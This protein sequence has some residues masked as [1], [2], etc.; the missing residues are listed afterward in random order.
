MRI[1]LMGYDDACMLKAEFSRQRHSTTKEVKPKS[2]SAE[3]RFLRAIDSDNLTNFT[4]TD[5]HRYI[6]IKCKEKGVRY[7]GGN[8]K[9][10]AVLKSALANFHPS[11][12]KL[13]IDFIFD[14]GQDRFD[15]KSNAVMALSKSWIDFT[16]NSSAEWDRQAGSFKKKP[17]KQAKQAEG[18]KKILKKRESSHARISHSKGHDL[19][20]GIHL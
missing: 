14:S 1:L 4:I 7:A 9:S 3:A 15:Y 12:I 2:N 8:V 18:R 10:N 6:N 5:W 16:F 17:D 13:M 20:G 19:G 11:A